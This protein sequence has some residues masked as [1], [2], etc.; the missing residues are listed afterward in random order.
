MFH[1]PNDNLVAR[2]CGEILVAQRARESTHLTFLL[3]PHPRREKLL[4][5][6]GLNT[7]QFKDP[8][9]SLL[10]LLF[11]PCDVVACSRVS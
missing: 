7:L 4:S 1:L 3:H 6:A 5:H 9:F 8:P 10:C 11:T 2:H